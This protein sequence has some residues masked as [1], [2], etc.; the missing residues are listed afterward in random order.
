MDE[1]R[2]RLDRLETLVG[3]AYNEDGVII[4]ALLNAI[5]QSDINQMRQEVQSVVN[6]LRENRP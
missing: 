3:V 2:A 4:P 6:F 5:N 1:M